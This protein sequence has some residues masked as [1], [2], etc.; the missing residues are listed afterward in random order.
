MSDISAEWKELR[1]KI[2]NF[3]CHMDSMNAQ[4]DAKLKK[5]QEKEEQQE[6][7]QEKI[8]EAYNKGIQDLYDAL[9]IFHEM[10]N[11]AIIDKFGST[12]LKKN[13]SIYF[14]ARSYV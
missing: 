5:L 7:V 4:N 9:K 1:Q 3:I 12:F 2:G 11:N 8:D 10:P 14:A 6:D 13:H